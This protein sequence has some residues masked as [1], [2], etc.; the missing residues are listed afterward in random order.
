MRRFL[1]I[2]VLVILLALS[3]CRR[4]HVLEDQSI[5]LALGY[6]AK[7]NHKFQVTASFL[8]SEQENKNTNRTITVEAD[9]SRAARRKINQM[10]PYELAIGQT[11]VILLNRNSFNLNMLNEIDVISRDPFFGDMIKIAIADSSAEDLL[12]HSYEKYSNIAVILN[13]LLEQNE[14]LNWTPSLTLHEFTYNQGKETLQPTVP[15]IKREGEEISLTAIA[16]LHGDRIVGEANPKEGF[17]LKALR[18]KSPPFLYETTIKKEDMKESGMDRYFLN[19]QAEEV[20]VVFRVIRGKGKIKL[21]DPDH[22]KFNANMK[23]N[24]NI[25][26]VSSKYMFN[27]PGAVE[28][29]EQQLDIQVT[30]DLQQFLDKIR[31]VN[32][33]CIGFGE[34]YRSHHGKLSAEEWSDKFPNS[35]IKGQVTNK[36]ISTGNL[37]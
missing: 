33:D 17:L 27:K 29:L 25:E 20:K 31:K 2:P 4:T 5:V 15:I 28:A 18:E 34:I 3:G 9:T 14:R 11:R 8:K 37:E 32:A 36:I 7:E 23:L 1:F 13:S 24:L 19:L 12:T 21:I 10:L 22:L 16:L 35:I 6:D 26:E 30:K